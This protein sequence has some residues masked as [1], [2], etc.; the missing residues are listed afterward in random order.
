MAEGGMYKEILLA[1]RRRWGTLSYYH[2]VGAVMQ[3]PEVMRTVG[4]YTN[5]GTGKRKS[6]TQA[7]LCCLARRLN[8]HSDV[9]RCIIIH[10]CGS[11]SWQARQ[12]DF[13]DLCPVLFSYT[14]PRPTSLHV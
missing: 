12:Q 3:A 11:T 6:T 1:A 4:V 7:H 8:G 9:D 2:P 13:V 5:Q 10:R 14:R